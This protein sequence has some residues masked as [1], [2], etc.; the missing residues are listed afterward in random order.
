MLGLVIFPTATAISTYYLPRQFYSQSTVQF[1]TLSS[2][3]DPLHEIASVMAQYGPAVDVKP[4]RD[5]DL[6]ELG[7]WDTNPAHAAMSANTA[8]MTLAQKFPAHVKIWEHAEPALAPGRP[9]VF[10]FIMMALAAG[11][12]SFLIGLILFLVARAPRPQPTSS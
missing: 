8:A 12:L 2:A 11:S 9:S 7:I 10:H 4:V 3:V 6:Y 5:T 1:I